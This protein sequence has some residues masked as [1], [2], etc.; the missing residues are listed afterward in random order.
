MKTFQEWIMK[1]KNDDDILGDFVNDFIRSNYKYDECYACAAA[2]EAYKEL[3]KRYSKYMVREEYK[4]FMNHFK[5]L[6]TVVGDEIFNYLK[7]FKQKGLLIE[8]RLSKIRLMT[9]EILYDIEVYSVVMYRYSKYIVEDVYKDFLIILEIIN[10]RNIVSD[11][12][13]YIK[14]PIENSSFEKGIKTFL[15]YRNRSKK[16][17]KLLKEAS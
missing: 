4:I 1:F 13:K 10:E 14:N 12:I 17:N 11:Y 16:I 3:N 6:N 7:I 2:R 5:S 9:P 8:P 15:Y